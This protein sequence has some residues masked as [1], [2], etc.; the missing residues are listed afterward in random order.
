MASGLMERGAGIGAFHVVARSR[1]VSAGTMGAKGAIVAVVIGVVA[2]A[3]LDVLWSQSLALETAFSETKSESDTKVASCACC[4]LVARE[5]VVEAFIKTSGLDT[6]CLGAFHS[7][8]LSSLVLVT[9]N[10]AQVI[11]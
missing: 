11:D 2:S 3:D 9:D 5:L 7:P 10:T 6:I 4:A 8:V 1:C